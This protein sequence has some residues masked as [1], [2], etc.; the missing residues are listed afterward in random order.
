MNKLGFGFLRIPQKQNT[1]EYD[2]KALDRLVDLYMDAGGRY[3]DTCYTYLD[4][5]SE[6]GIRRSVVSRK[7]REDF[8]LTEKIPG[9]LCRK[10]EDAE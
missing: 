3:F 6:E 5:H 10:P 8:C 4:G 9:Y 7:R 2:W 1:N